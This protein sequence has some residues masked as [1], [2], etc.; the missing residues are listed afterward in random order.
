MASVLEKLK[1]LK[2]EERKIEAEAEAKKQATQAEAAKLMDQAK[3]EIMTKVKAN[4]DEFKNL[5]LSIWEIGTLFASQ[6]GLPIGKTKVA[7]KASGTKGTRQ[8]NTDQ[9]CKICGFKT[10]P[11]HD[12]RRHRSQAEKRPFTAKELTDMGMQKVS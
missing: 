1:K 4:V 5:G 11:Y 2:E 10:E 6:L 7:I 8:T 9:P 3:D 12:A